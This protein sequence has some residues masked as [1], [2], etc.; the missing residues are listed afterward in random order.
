MPNNKKKRNRYDYVISAKMRGGHWSYYQGDIFRPNPK[1]KVIRRKD[2]VRGNMEPLFTSH[3]YCAEGMT[4]KEAIHTACLWLETR[5]GTGVEIV[6]RFIISKKVR[7][8]MHK[9]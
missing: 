1:G 8:K 7:R 5:Q 3:L 9:K 6:R 2:D 4:R